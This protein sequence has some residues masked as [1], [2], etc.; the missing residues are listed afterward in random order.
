MEERLYSVY[1][2]TNIINGKKYVGR[3]SDPIRR[4]GKDGIGYKNQFFYEKGISKYGWNNFTHE[5][6]ASNLSLK[7]SQELETELI[8]FY[9]TID[10]N[11]GYNKIDGDYYKTSKKFYLTKKIICLETGIVYNSL[12][13]AAAKVGNDP[14]AGSNFMKVCKQKRKS[15]YGYHWAIYE[16]DID[17]TKNEFYMK[18]KLEVIKKGKKR[19]VRCIETGEI[20][21]SAKQAAEKLGFK[22]Y[23]HISEVCLKSNNSA[24]KKAYGYTWEF[25]D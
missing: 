2:H 13:E 24:R 22:N 6:V 7:E 5:I 18:E 17:Y 8:Y 10:E 3:S 14:S 11:Y 25:V 19:K 12:T 1:I 23:S 15:A 9:N 16:E 21:D 20:Y 4:W